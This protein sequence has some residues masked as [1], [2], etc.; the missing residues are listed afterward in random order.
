MKLLVIVDQE[1]RLDTERL[2][3]ISK[4]PVNINS[5]ISEGISVYTCGKPVPWDEE[6]T[7]FIQIGECSAERKMEPSVIIDR[8]SDVLGE[9]LDHVATMQD[10]D[11]ATVEEITES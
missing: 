2:K 9:L 3:S 1:V 8:K 6:W 7:A 11:A 4:E 5:P 10:A